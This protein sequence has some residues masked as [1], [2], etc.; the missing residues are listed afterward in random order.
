MDGRTDIWN[1]IKAS[2]K[3]YLMKGTLLQKNYITPHPT[4]NPTKG[5]IKHAIGGRGLSRGAFLGQLN[6]AGKIPYILKEP[7][8]PTH[9]PKS[10]LFV[11]FRFFK[12][13]N[14]FRVIKMLKNKFE[15]LE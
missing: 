10:T 4:P 14:K 1:Y 11:N 3:N 2:L 5:S 7:P 13:I 12:G 9:F 8:P 15:V 6:P